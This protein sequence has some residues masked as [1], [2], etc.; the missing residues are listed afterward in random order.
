MRLVVAVLVFLLAIVAAAV[1]A[2]WAYGKAFGT[3]FDICPGGVCYSGWLGVA[4]FAVLTFVLCL[5]GWRLLSG[6]GH[7]MRTR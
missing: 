6:G 7:R 5:A 1:T 4:A 3:E 2:L